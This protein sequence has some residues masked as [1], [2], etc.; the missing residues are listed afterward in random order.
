[1][2]LFWTL[3]ILFQVW[4]AFQTSMQP[5]NAAKGSFRH[6]ERAAALKATS[7]D[8]PSPE[9]KAALRRELILNAEHI[10]RWQ[11]IHAGIW[12]AVF[13]ALDI[14]GYRAWKNP[15]RNF[16]YNPLIS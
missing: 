14:A 4:F 13:L 9:A 15:P 10:A 11:F 12:L 16:G 6:E 7:S 2:R 8:N 5:F 3:L 1:M